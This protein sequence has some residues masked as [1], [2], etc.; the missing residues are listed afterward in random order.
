MNSPTTKQLARE[1]FQQFIADAPDS[2]YA[3][4][5]LFRLGTAYYQEEHYQQAI[6]DYLQ[7]CTTYPKVQTSNV[8]SS[9]LGIAILLSGSQNRP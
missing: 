3:D 6:D 2:E 9:C 8:P 5:A 7:L 4:D 1:T